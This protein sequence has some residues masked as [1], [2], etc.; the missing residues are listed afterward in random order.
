MCNNLVSNAEGILGLVLSSSS[1]SRSTG[2]FL[3]AIVVSGSRS[4]SGEGELAV[5]EREMLE[6]FEERA[7][8]GRF[9]GWD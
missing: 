6:M 7:V 2:R 8:E 3:R 1:S 4:A 5:A 9:R